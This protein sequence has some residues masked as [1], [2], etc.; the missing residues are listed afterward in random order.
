MAYTDHEN[1]ISP[2]LPYAIQRRGLRN[3][4]V[5]GMGNRGYAIGELA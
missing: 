1:S 4:E 3:H 2:I 5:H